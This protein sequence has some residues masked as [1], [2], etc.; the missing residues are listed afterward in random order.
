MQRHVPAL[1]TVISKCPETGRPCYF[2]LARP[3][4][5]SLVLRSIA[6]LDPTSLAYSEAVADIYENPFY[7]ET[8]EPLWQAFLLVPDNTSETSFEARVLFRV[9][10]II[11]DGLSGPYMHEQLS[12]LLCDPQHKLWTATPVFQK[13]APPTT[14]VWDWRYS[15]AM[16]LQSWCSQRIVGFFKRLY[17]DYFGDRCK[18]IDFCAKWRNTLETVLLDQVLLQNLK[19]KSKQHEVTIGNMVT[20]AIQRAFDQMEIRRPSDKKTSHV[21]V[22]RRPLYA[23]TRTWTP[24]IGYAAATTLHPAL[25]HT[26]AFNRLQGVRPGEYKA[27]YEKQLSFWDACRLVQTQAVSGTTQQSAAKMLADLEA[28]PKEA[29]QD[30]RPADCRSQNAKQDMVVTGMERNLARTRIHDERELWLCISN[31]I[32]SDLRQNDEWTIDKLVWIN[33]ITP[34]LERG[35][36]VAVAGDASGSSISA[37]YDPAKVDNKEMRKM[38]ETTRRLLLHAATDELES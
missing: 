8:L 7:V 33:N 6:S 24:G 37:C 34:V 21:V 13:L 10:H 11:F 22:T 16:K 26:S 38:L 1:R 27:M 31:T 20:V 3:E 29:W 9:S 28:A 32:K 36:I 4:A 25:N 15:L 12:E 19:W 18:S 23:M 35:I 30:W 14:E 2:Q 5:P 17:L